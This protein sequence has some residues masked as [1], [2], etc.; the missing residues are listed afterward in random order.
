MRLRTLGA[1]IVCTGLATPVEAQQLPDGTDLRAAYCA[2]LLSRQIESHRALMS[3]LGN[4]PE[5]PELQAVRA[6]NQGV[7]D[8]HRRLL[9][10]L[11]PRLSHLDVQPLI[12]ASKTADADIDANGRLQQEAGCIGKELDAAV[13][14]SRAVLANAPATSK[15]KQCETV[16]WLPF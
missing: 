15:Q 7:E 6:K 16:D 1:I 8:R 12:A 13:A 11:E 3:L 5:S 10:Y 9:A 2:R 4:V 14:C